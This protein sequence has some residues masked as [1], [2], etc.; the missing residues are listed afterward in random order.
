[1]IKL[2]SIVGV[3]TLSVLSFFS[4]QAQTSDKVVLVGKVDPKYNSTKVYLYNNITGDNDTTVVENGAWRIELPFTVPTRH[5][6]AS[7]AESKKHG[8]YAPFGVLVDEPGTVVVEGD[9][10]SFYTSKVSGSKS[11]D[12]LNQYFAQTQEQGG[13][14][15]AIIADIVSKNANVFGSAFL[16][17]RYGKVMTPEDALKS[18]EGLS[19]EVKQTYFGKSAGNQIKGALL[20]KEGAIVKD[21]ALANEKGEQLNFASLRGNYVLLDFWASWCGPC[22]E[23]FKTLKEVYAKYKGKAPF[24]ILSISTDKSEAAWK[25]ALKNQQL[26]WLQ[27][28]DKSGED[29]IAVSQFAVTTLPTTFLIGPDGKI[30]AK[31]LRGEEL[32]AYL[33][34]LFGN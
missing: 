34:K 27:M 13:N 4:V 33:V 8:G 25:N 10:E 17:E 24:E 21:F 7:E 26:P 2:R 6:L 20:S 15:A 32:V 5:M 28:H 29:A 11:H 19:A 18:Y 1:M 22:I 30:V 9:L 3:F 12:V 14:N 16:L 31:N 23:E